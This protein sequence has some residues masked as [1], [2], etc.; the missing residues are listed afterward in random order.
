MPGLLSKMSFSLRWGMLQSIKMPMIAQILLKQFY[1]LSRVFD[2]LNWFSQMIFWVIPHELHSLPRILSCYRC[3]WQRRLLLHMQFHAASNLLTNIPLASFLTVYLYNSDIVD[4]IFISHIVGR[5]LSSTPLFAIY[6]HADYN[7]D[8]WL[9]RALIQQFSRFHAGMM[10]I[11][12]AHY[13]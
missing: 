7:T 11:S 6:G 12:Q 9:L 3:R 5:L 13:F 4:E 1:G 8:S 2:G 10:T